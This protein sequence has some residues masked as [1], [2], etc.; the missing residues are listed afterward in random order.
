MNLIKRIFGKDDQKESEHSNNFP[1]DPEKVKEL[2]PELRVRYYAN[3]DPDGIRNDKEAADYL[4]ESSERQNLTYRIHNVERLPR[5]ILEDAVV[6]DARLIL[7]TPFED[8]FRITPFKENLGTT[9]EDNLRKTVN[10]ATQNNLDLSTRISPILS[11]VLD[12]TIG[13]YDDKRQ[14]G[15]GLYRGIRNDIEK[16][17]WNVLYLVELGKSIDYTPSENQSENIQAIYENAMN[18]GDS[19]HRFNFAQIL[20]NEGDKE[21]VI[22]DVVAGLNRDYESRF[23]HCKRDWPNEAYF[24][25]EFQGLELP[26]KQ[27]REYNKRMLDGVVTETAWGLISSKEQNGETER[28]K[29]HDANVMFEGFFS[30]RKIKRAV[31]KRKAEIKRQLKK[32]EQKGKKEEQKSLGDALVKEEYRQAIKLAHSLGRP[33]REI[34]GY[35]QLLLTNSV[36]GE[37]DEGSVKNLVSIAQRYNLKEGL[38]DVGIQAVPHLF[39]NG[40]TK[41]QIQYLLE[42]GAVLESEVQEKAF[43]KLRESVGSNSVEGRNLISLVEEG[44]LRS[45]EPARSLISVLDATYER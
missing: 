15:Q 14:K 13:S 5:N 25:R 33:Q 19:M 38:R 7:S 36:K 28:Y 45:Y 8:N 10:F 23:L 26:P 16:D 44:H 40:Y 12:E 35:A 42:T 34:A 20:E 9:F 29:L 39:S 11:D 6:S 2:S 43:E 32:E 30:P 27:K 31:F 3:T 21:K 37:M 22:E 4:R 1:L 41:S 24:I 18:E 17:F